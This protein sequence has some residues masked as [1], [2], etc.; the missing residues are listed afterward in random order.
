MSSDLNS[1]SLVGRLTK[2]A[3]LKFT[4]SGTAVAELGIA[5]NESVKRGDAW[6]DEASFFNCQL[7]GKRAESLA[8]YLIKGTRIA[9]EG[10][11]KQSRWKDKEGQN[12]SSVGIKIGNIQLL[13][14]GKRD[15][16]QSGGYQKQQGNNSYN[17]GANNKPQQGYDRNATFD[18]DIPF[19]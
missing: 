13:G 1:I 8:Q 12:R 19:V 5:V 18:E 14:D 9:I 17:S 6:E 3:E 4:N 7:W 15:N 16:N 10:R 11:L 2:D